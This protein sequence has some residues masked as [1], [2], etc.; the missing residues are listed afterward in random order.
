MVWK[1]KTRNQTKEI[2]QWKSTIKQ[3][4]NKIQEWPKSH[5][6][7]NCEFLELYTY[8]WN[9]SKYPYSSKPKYF[10]NFELQTKKRQFKNNWIPIFH[11]SQTYQGICLNYIPYTWVCNSSRNHYNPNST[12]IIRFLVLWSLR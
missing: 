12:W 1:S 8:I 3:M 5:V 10:M 6:S 7:I 2:K 11:Q 4:K 9:A